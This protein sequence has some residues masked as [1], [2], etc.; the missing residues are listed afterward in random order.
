MHGVQKHVGSR[1][2]G[3]WQL[4]AKPNNIGSVR[5]EPLSYELRFERVGARAKAMQVNQMACGESSFFRD[6]LG[7]ISLPLEQ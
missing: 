4:R 2:R 7:Q 6:S 1:M 5:F 3:G